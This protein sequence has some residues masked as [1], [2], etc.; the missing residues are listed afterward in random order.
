MESDDIVDK[1]HQVRDTQRLNAILAGH[2]FNLRVYTANGGG[3]GLAVIHYRPMR[4]REDIDEVIEERRL[5][6]E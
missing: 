6:D 4:C 5:R 3:K 2:P 1:L